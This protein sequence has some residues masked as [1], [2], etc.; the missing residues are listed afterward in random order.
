MLSVIIDSSKIILEYLQTIVPELPCRRSYDPI[1][2]ITELKMVGKP[3]VLVVPV[4]RIG[5]LFRDGGV[6][7]NDLIFDIVVNSKLQNTDEPTLLVSE[8]DDLMLTVEKI[9]AAFQKITLKND[10]YNMEVHLI[11]SEHFV[12]NDVEMIR[13]NNCFLSAIRVNTKVFVN[14]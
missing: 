4:E 9:F 14:S 11:D 10:E 7:K 5:T 3:I 6:L 2:S 13:E 8:I 12:L 1:T